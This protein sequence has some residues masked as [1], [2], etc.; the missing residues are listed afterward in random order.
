MRPSLSAS[1]RSTWRS[2]RSRCASLSSASFVAVAAAQLVEQAVANVDVESL[3]AAQAHR[4][5]Q[6]RELEVGG[7]GRRA[8]VLRE[9]VRAGRPRGGRRRP[10]AP[11]SSNCAIAR[12][13]VGRRSVATGRAAGRRRAACRGRPL[14]SAA[15]R[16]TADA[17]SRAR[18]LNASRTTSSPSTS[19]G[20]PAPSSATHGGHALLPGRGTRKCSCSAGRRRRDAAALGALGAARETIG[21]VGRRAGAH[22]AGELVERPDRVVQPVRLGAALGGGRGDL[23]ERGQAALGVAARAR[24]GV[25]RVAGDRAPQPREV[26]VGQRAGDVPAVLGDVHRAVAPDRERLAHTVASASHDQAPRTRPLTPADRCAQRS[27]QRRAGGPPWRPQSARSA[28]L[29]SPRRLPAPR[30]AL[31]LSEMQF[32]ALQGAERTSISS[33]G[34]ASRHRWR[35][36]ACSELPRQSPAGG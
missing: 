9:R 22:P 11:R 10:S 29:A 13:P 23:G 19:S 34:A 18:D 26:V 2:M 16:P 32:L 1:R 12:A 35:A 30:S 25:A 7:V 8:P 24:R 3:H 28:L 27:R 4:R 20:L 5:R 17:H 6:A 31:P 36:R 15:A 33:W 14:T 21:S